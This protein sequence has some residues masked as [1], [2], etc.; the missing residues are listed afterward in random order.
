VG[1]QD[2]QA[3]AQAKASF[4][5]YNRAGNKYI[6]GLQNRREREIKWFGQGQPDQGPPLAGQTV[7]PQSPVSQLVQPRSVKTQAITPNAPQDDEMH[8][9][10]GGGQDPSAGG[11]S[12]PS[13]FAFA[14]RGAMGYG[15]AEG[16]K[17]D[18]RRLSVA[19]PENATF[20]ENS[21]GNIGPTGEP[22]SSAGLGTNVTT[23]ANR[24]PGAGPAGEPNTVSPQAA[25][26]AAQFAGGRPSADLGDEN[27]A[28]RGSPGGIDYNKD[29]MMR[30]GGKT[31]ESPEDLDIH[32]TT[33]GEQVAQNSGDSRGTATRATAASGEMINLPGY[34]GPM[35]PVPHLPGEAEVR[36]LLRSPQI[37]QDPEQQKRILDD[38]T[39][40]AAPTSVPVPGGNLV[41]TPGYNDKHSAQFFPSNALVPTEAAG[42]KVEAERQFDKNGQP[43][44]HPLIAGGPAQAGSTAQSGTQGQPSQLGQTDQTRPSDKGPLGPILPLIRQSQQLQSEQKEEVAG[45][46]TRGKDYEDQRA[47]LNEMGNNADAQRKV[48]D[49]MERLVHD[50]NFISG[51]GKDTRLDL[52]KIRA[53]FGDH[54]GAAATEAFDKLQA[55]SVLEGIKSL[56]GLGQIRVAEMNLT[57]KATANRTMTPAAIQAVIDINRRGLGKVQ[58]LR[59][60]AQ[61]YTAQHG[62]LD[63]GWDKTASDI[64][65]KPLFN[66]DELSRYG[67]ML[68][69]HVRVKGNSLDE[70]LADAKAKGVKP[71]EPIVLP[72]NRVKEMPGLA[73]QPT[74]RFEKVPETNQWSRVPM[75]PYG[76][77]QPNAT[78]N[79]PPVDPNVLRKDQV[80]DDP[81]TRAMIDA[82]NNARGRINM[83]GKLDRLKTRQDLLYNYQQGRRQ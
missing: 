30:L 43:V 38:W 47:G 37:A 26:I 48:Y 61:A 42:V 9:G 72:D 29:G 13:R 5:Q 66:D 73:K 16:D 55:G 33:Q 25:R 44:M 58:E 21:R 22:L 69:G 71:R 77:P 78:P 53:Y 70:V 8:L 68:S 52:A 40:R 64:M 39:K 63:R 23:N 76:P 54:G 15:F 24:T 7:Q 74:S 10:I 3:L 19:N 27:S 28:I 32:K 4:M 67:N 2:Q 36:A 1:G 62:H 6:Q 45:A 83:Q 41:I 35:P 75:T 31:D 12:A 59:D 51:A 34:R 49:I 65:G 18:K 56:K 50:P 80:I 11:S 81:Q 60:A 57:E 79:T 20:A 14:P 17:G 46:E 82:L